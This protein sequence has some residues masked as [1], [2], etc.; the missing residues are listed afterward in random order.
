M[1][2]NDPVRPEVR[3]EVSGYVKPQAYLSSS[4]AR[5][6]GKVG[7]VI[8]QT[9][10]ITPTPE[11][12]FKILGIDLDQGDFIRYDLKEIKNSQGKAYELT[13]FN[14]KQDKG[15]YRDKIFIKTDSSISPELKIQVLGLVRNDP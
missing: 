7:Q 5:L 4:V 1:R 10:T 2:T 6:T 14:T 12:P 8:S 15:W 3:L 13:I 9:V 11:N